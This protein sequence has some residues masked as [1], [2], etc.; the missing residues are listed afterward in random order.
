MQP[1]EILYLAAGAAG[2]FVVLHLVIFWVARFLYPPVKQV[3][4][5]RHP[6]PLPVQQAPPPPPTVVYTQPPPQP[7]VMAPPPNISNP[8]SP[9]PAYTEVAGHA[10]VPVINNEP[11]PPPIQVGKRPEDDQTGIAA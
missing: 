8:M 5:P 4:V 2:V 11:L 10:Q 9:P 6:V 7:V 3:Y 1:L